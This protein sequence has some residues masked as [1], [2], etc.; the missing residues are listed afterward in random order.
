M[1]TM[2]TQSQLLVLE[3]KEEK[4]PSNNLQP[5]ML[6]LYSYDFGSRFKP[7]PFAPSPS[8][9]KVEAPAVEDF[10]SAN[11]RMPQNKNRFTQICS[12]FGS[13]DTQIYDV[14]ERFFKSQWELENFD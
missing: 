2:F 11:C 13:Q 12:S 14:D 8:S 1:T 7:S 5:C 9:K 3:K 10:P 4:E 6:L